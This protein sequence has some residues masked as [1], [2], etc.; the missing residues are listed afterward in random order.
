MYVV[1]PTPA[2]RTGSLPEIM[3]TGCRIEWILVD[4][5]RSSQRNREPRMKVAVV[6]ATRNEARTIAGVTAAA[7]AG[8]SA[9]G[10]G[11][12]IVNSDGGSEDGTGQ[13]F[14]ATPTDTPKRLLTVEGEP[15]KG[16]NLL[17]A[18]RLCLD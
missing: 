12:L 3:M 16:R 4:T 10:C 5:F 17:A 1:W 2:S 14:L 15:G 18:W 7:D 13:A 6:I 11:G 8:L 9:L